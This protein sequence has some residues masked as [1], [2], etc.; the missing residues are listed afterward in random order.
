[1]NI[2]EHFI[3]T[4]TTIYENAETAIMINGEMSSNFKIKRGVRQG[5]PLSCLLFDMAIEPLAEMIRKSTLKG[6][7][8]PSLSYR[9]VTTLFADDTVV[10]M[11][12]EDDF[13]I[14]EDLLDK[15]CTASGARFNK[16]KTQ[17]I[18]IGTEEYRQLVIETR[19]LSSES[20]EIPDTINILKEGDATRILGAWI[21]NQTNEEG[22]WTPIIEKIDSSLSAWNKMY[23]TIE[24]RKILTQWIVGGKTQYLVTAQGM[25]K[26]IEKLLIHKIQNFIWDNSGKLAISK[27]TLYTPINEGGKGLL[28]L[29]S[30]N[31]A[32]DLNHLKSLVNKTSPWTHF[33]H[34]IIAK[35]VKPTPKVPQEIL[36]NFFIQSWNTRV[37]KLPLGLRRIIK[38]GNKYGMNIDTLAIDKESKENM[39]IWYHLYANTNLNKLNNAYYSKC[40]R[41]NHN[42]WT[43]KQI[44]EYLNG[45]TPNHR[46]KAECP[47][48]HCKID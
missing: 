5:C 20:S 31:E 46:Q 18:P 8:V 9:I 33:A 27:A 19:K 32:I 25:P 14:L 11:T 28:D 10:Y 34:E 43:V 23:P 35:Q 22:I 26:E 3:N 39:L 13:Q 7:S 42:I 44:V 38:T 37:K 45:N 48:E 17:I 30:R 47:C 1:M 6:F 4:V 41:E 21:G 29:E 15:W 2:P 16:N 36:Q 40:L 24:G 12:S